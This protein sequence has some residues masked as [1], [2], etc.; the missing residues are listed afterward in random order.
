MFRRLEGLFGGAPQ[1]KRV[2]KKKT[3]IE[4]DEGN[5]LVLAQEEVTEKDPI[6]GWTTTQ[7]LWSEVLPCGHRVTS[8]KQVAGRCYVDGTLVCTECLSRCAECGEMVC[9]QH[10][11]M[12]AEDGK[13]YC[14]ACWRRRKW[15]KAFAAIGRVVIWP[16]AEKV[17]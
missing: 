6:H 12:S 3:V 15:K 5:E 7:T 1:P 17:R 16:F 10:A 9:R 4:N 8:Y 13:G 14:R 11:K 2:K